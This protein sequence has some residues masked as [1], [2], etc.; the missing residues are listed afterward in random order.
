M[1]ISSLASLSLFFFFL[2][3]WIVS[4]FSIMSFT[5]FRKSQSYIICCLH[6]DESENPQKKKKNYMLCIFYLKTDI[7]FSFLFF[8]SSFHAVF[9]RFFSLD[10]SLMVE[11]LGI[12][13]YACFSKAKV[14]K[15]KNLQNVYICIIYHTD[16]ILIFFFPF[17]CL[18]ICIILR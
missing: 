4:F 11:V 10:M 7:I 6:R 8:T 13:Y 5:G 1:L 18:W 3:P 15:K 17:P 12:L 14:E 16:T 2:P 9:F